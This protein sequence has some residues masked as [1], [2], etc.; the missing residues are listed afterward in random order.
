MG[1]AVTAA[2]GGGTA[3]RA[4]AFAIWLVP[5]P[6]G[7]VIPPGTKTVDVFVDRFDHQAFPVSTI[8]ARWK[9]RQLVALINSRQ[10]E[11]PGVAIACPGLGPDSPL[12]DLRLMSA[13]GSTQLARALEDGCGGLSFWIR[14]RAQRGLSEDQDLTAMLWRLGALPVCRAGQ[15]G[16]S[17]ST[18]TRFPA[19]PTIT[20]QLLFRNVSSTT[21]AL[22]GFARLRFRA[23]SGLRLPTHV[24][25]AIG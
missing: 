6:A 21:C 3:M 24:N 19:L 2:K 23:A 9:I 16:G 11:Q 7:E 5:R 14:G 15:L 18:P 20:A 8:T 12:L 10:I 17:A 13:S 4:D 1:I 25:N 22:R